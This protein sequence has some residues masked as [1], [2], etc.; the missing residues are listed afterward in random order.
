MSNHASELEL[1]QLA[2]RELEPAVARGLR[3]HMDDCLS[4]RSNFIEIAETNDRYRDWH[5]TLKVLDPAPPH[6]WPA[7]D[8]SGQALQPPIS[9]P[10]RSR[11]RRLSVQLAAAALLL[12]G[13]MVY[14]IQR[15][16]K[17]SAAEL[18]R[19][20]VAAAPA[21][22]P[23]VRIRIRAGNRSLVRPA[24]LRTTTGESE[25]AALFLQAHYEWDDPFSAR[26][27]AAWRDQ[28]AEKR[29]RVD[30]LPGRLYQIRTATHSS[31]LSEAELYLRIPDL[32][33]VREILRF[34]VQVVE[35]EDAQPETAPSV[36][37][38]VLAPTPP[39]IPRPEALA[40]PAEELHVVAALHRIG[41]DLGD[42][43]EVGRE[44][45]SVVVN[46]TG[47]TAARE[48]QIRESLADLP[49]VAFRIHEPA[50]GHMSS[51][52]SRIDVTAA[53][54]SA[55]GERLGNNTVNAI[56]DASEAVMAR[57]YAL[58]TLSKRFPILV[59]AQLSDADQGVLARLRGEHS[60]ALAAHLRE[61]RAAIAPVLPEASV[62][63]AR[64]AP[65]WQTA[66]DRI[67]HAAQGVD[68]LLSAVLAGSEGSADR[69]P[70]LASAM[71]QLDA[72]VR[73]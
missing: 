3:R 67:F 42:P 34:G 72:E 26:A 21:P 43:I 53:A 64:A 45:P 52:G 57:A 62:P 40:G 51:V 35:I 49:G 31:S 24:V 41:A 18:L 13:F 38:P 44:G 59:E 46:A 30:T 17:V 6:P 8:F 4:C 14:R 7:L 66:A 11:F 20:A 36:P 2:D 73:Q 9:M 15:A 22:R 25:I 54:H 5:A 69:L 58:R 48:Q 33:P 63:Q 10:A 65:D 27:F 32:Q 71:K 55:V 70:D 68:Q 56:L 60:S 12:A 39:R 29:D 37:P 16:P 19:Q 50:A 1:L 61:L 47:L 23:G 28:L